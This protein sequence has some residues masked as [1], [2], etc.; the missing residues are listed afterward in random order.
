[1]QIFSAGRVHELR[2]GPVQRCVRFQVLL[3]PSL[4]LTLPPKRFPICNR[5]CPCSASVACST[6]CRACHLRIHVHLSLLHG[7]RTYVWVTR[8]NN[9]YSAMDITHQRRDRYQCLAASICQENVCSPLGR[10]RLQLNRL[11]DFCSN[12]KTKRKMLVE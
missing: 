8:V 9:F 12:K 7:V 1:M 6:W 10:R 3:N 4:V 5:W 2:T 11:E